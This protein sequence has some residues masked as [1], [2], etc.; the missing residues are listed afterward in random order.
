MKFHDF[1]VLQRK[2]TLTQKQMSKTYWIPKEWLMF[3]HRGLGSIDFH[4]KTWIHDFSM[5]TLDFRDFMR[6]LWKS[7]KTRKYGKRDLAENG[8]RP[9]PVINPA[10]FIIGA[11]D[12]GCVSAG[13]NG[14][15]LFLIFQDPGVA[16]FPPPLPPPRAT[17]APPRIKKSKKC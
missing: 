10:L 8:A 7:L 16:P 9:G 17:P 6:F 12:L 5:Q 3:S 1:H 11:L 2:S 4:A 15:L 13:G 14:F